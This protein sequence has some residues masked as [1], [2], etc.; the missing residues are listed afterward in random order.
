MATQL[1][2]NKFMTEFEKKFG[3]SIPLLAQ[4]EFFAD[5]L[6]R[7]NLA[8][9]I[10][11]LND[12]S[13]LEMFLDEDE[14]DPLSGVEFVEKELDRI[15]EE[16][17]SDHGFRVLRVA[18]AGWPGTVKDMETLML[19]VMDDMDLLDD[20]PDVIVEPTVDI[21]LKADELKTLFSVVQEYTGPES[22]RLYSMLIVRKLERFATGRPLSEKFARLNQ[23]SSEHELKAALAELGE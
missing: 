4:D 2:V 10:D 18:F 20:H 5:V 8:N 13:L 9:F 7:A 17:G 3:L 21:A 23:T 15:A 12:E 1:E 16:L 19:S 11:C 22:L 14:P 6:E